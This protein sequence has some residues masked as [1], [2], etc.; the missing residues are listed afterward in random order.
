MSLNFNKPG[1]LKAVQSDHTW[2]NGIMCHVVYWVG[3]ILG[4]MAYI[5]MT[6]SGW[7]DD[8]HVDDENI[9]DD[10]S[11]CN[12][13]YDDTEKYDHDDENDDYDDDVII[14]NDTEN[15]DDD[16]DGN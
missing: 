13:N 14:D 11:D 6:I 1:I 2:N 10:S 3:N 12:G 5:E 15:L 8:N 16:E 4:I 9:D 7:N